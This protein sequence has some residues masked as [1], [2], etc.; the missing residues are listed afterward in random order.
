MAIFFSLFA[1]IGRCARSSVINFFLFSISAIGLVF[2]TGETTIAVIIG[3]AYAS[4]CSLLLLM[5]KILKESINTQKKHRVIFIVLLSMF[6][7]LFTPNK[8][9]LYDTIPQI[10]KIFYGELKE[11]TA[12]ISLIFIV[13]TIGLISLLPKN[14][15]K[16]K[17]QVDD[18]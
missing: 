18:V 1:I 4:T 13:T 12:L 2:L 11:A 17:T 16:I 6:A 14:K 5:T 10:T 9:E 3:M 8:G 15:N 7:M